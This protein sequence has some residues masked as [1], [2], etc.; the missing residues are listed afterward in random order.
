MI[1]TKALKM[2]LESDADSGREYVEVSET[3]DHKH[4][5]LNI[6]NKAMA[7][8][9]KAEWK[10]LCEWQYHL[11]VEDDGDESETPEETSDVVE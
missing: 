4:L 5:R 10:A 8:L 1:V 9:T 3:R 11:N 7:I 2:T 6:S